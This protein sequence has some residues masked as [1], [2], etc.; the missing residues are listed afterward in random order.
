MKILPR[1]G[2]MLQTPGRWRTRGVV[3]RRRSFRIAGHGRT[4]RKHDSVQTV[5]VPA[6]GAGFLSRSSRAPRMW[7]LITS[8]AAAEISGGEQLGRPRVLLNGAQRTADDLHC[9]DH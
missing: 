6:S 2:A 4:D 5:A 9:F 8:W 1:P 3:R 7:A